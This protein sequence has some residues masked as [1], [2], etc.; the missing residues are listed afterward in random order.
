MEV[1]CNLVETERA[2]HPAG[3]IE[4]RAGDFEPAL[5]PLAGTDAPL[6][7]N[8]ISRL[9]RQFKAAYTA[10]DRQDLSDR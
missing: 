9:T 1:A 4:T 8:T 3:A 6:S 7:P 10:L 2:G 5:R